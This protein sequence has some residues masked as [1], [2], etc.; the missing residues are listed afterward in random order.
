MQGTYKYLKTI[1]LISIIGANIKISSE[2]IRYGFLKSNKKALQILTLFLVHLCETK[3]EN[4]RAD[5]FRIARNKL[6]LC[7]Q[8]L[9]A[10]IKLCC[11]TLHTQLSLVFSFFNKS[12][13]RN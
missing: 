4:L 7:L 12:V 3:S 8:V 5:G 11:G 6:Y 10:Y 9:N 13:Y 2:H 1:T